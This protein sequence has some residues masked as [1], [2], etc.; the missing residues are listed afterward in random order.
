M[1]TRVHGDYH[2]GQVL[3]TGEDFVILDFEGEPAKPLGVRLEKQSPAKDVVGMLR[4]F[5][6]A[7]FAAL[8]AFAKDRPDRLERLGPWA[9]LWQVWTS[10]AF[11]REYLAVA[12][13]APFLPADPADFALLLEA[14][15]LDKALYELLYELNNRPDWV[16]IPLRGVLRLIEV[17][18]PPPSGEAAPPS[19]AVPAPPIA[20]ASRISDFD[21]HLFGE[22]THDRLYEKMVCIGPIRTARAGWPSPS[23]P[24]TRGPSRSSATST[25]GR[26]TPIG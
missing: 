23:G 3:R 21:L 19:D 7:A 5:D 22:G 4:S 20:V 12:S 26:P 9:R 14:F 15:T 1:K 18:T 11:L 25:A 10:A 17:G 8:F 24:P 6:Y 16:G 2:L 13:G